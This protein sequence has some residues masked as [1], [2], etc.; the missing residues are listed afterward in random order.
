M[1][2]FAIPNHQRNPHRF[3][4]DSGIL[5]RACWHGSKRTTAR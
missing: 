2:N 4:V 1:T 5:A 3:P